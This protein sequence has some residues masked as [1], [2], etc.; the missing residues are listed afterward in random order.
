M[1]PWLDRLSARVLVLAALA[2]AYF[3]VFPGDAEAVTGPIAVVLRLTQA[4]SPWLYAMIA[5]A[6]FSGAMVR[7]WRREAAPR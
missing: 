5:V 6:I 3:V 2:F 7:T 4:V 1:S